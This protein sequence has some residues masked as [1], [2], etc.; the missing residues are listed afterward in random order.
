MGLRGPAPEPS[1]LR[2][3]R[4]NPSKRP[5]GKREPRPAENEP[6][7]PVYLT[8]SARR[9]WRRLVPV[10][11]RMRVLTEADGHA[12]AMLAEAWAKKVEL[13]KRVDKIG[14][15]IKT[16]SGYVQV[17]PLV[18]MIR[19]QDQKLITLLREFGLT[20]AARVR[21]QTVDQGDKQDPLEMALAQPSHSETECTLQ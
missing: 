19:E 17:N 10:L 13:T 11:A 8:P 16:P 20:P 5:M 7:M 18:S 6:R 3:A 4:G 2:K 21:L 9:E 1:V 15:V 14:P 12:L